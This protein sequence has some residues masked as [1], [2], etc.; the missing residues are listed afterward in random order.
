M[1][2]E[3]T[4]WSRTTL[5]TIDFA[6]ARGADRVA[7]NARIGLD[8]DGPM[9]PDARLPVS[10]YYA[11]VEAAAEALGDPYFGIHYIEQVQPGS[12]D[13]V[14]F[15]AMASQ[16]LG[17][18]VA[19]II[20]HHPM[21]TEGEVFDLEVVGDRAIVR[22]VPWGP[23]RPAHGQIAEMYAADFFILSPRVTGAPIEPISFELAHPPA[24]EARV[25]QRLFGAQ[26]RA[27]FQQ[28]HLQAGPPQQRGGGGAADAG[29]RD[30]D[31]EAKV[32]VHG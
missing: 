26:P 7:L 10:T 15:L 32:L 6:V 24:G 27:L 31:V 4:C 25:Y 16:T 29:A 21:M 19:R 20:R 11:T 1:A 23:G 13:A 9:D 3:P 2:A 22:Y 28:S 8:G 18:A 5:A 17:E 14:G 30:D 12:I